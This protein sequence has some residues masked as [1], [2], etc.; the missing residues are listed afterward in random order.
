MIEEQKPKGPKQKRQNPSSGYCL[1]CN[2]KI[3]H[4]SFCDAW[5]KED[6]EFEQEMR[7]T[8]GKPRK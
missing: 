3:D 7:K 2:A 8:M 4:G 1:Y 6:Y 5:C